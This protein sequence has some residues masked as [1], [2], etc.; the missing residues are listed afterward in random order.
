MARR[1]RHLEHHRHVALLGHA[2][3]RRGLGNAGHQA[4]KHQQPLVKHKVETH[5]ALLQQRGNLL[6]TARTTRLLVSAVGQVNGARRL[7]AAGQQHLDGLHLRKQVALV[8]PRA[9]APDEAVFDLTGK[10]RHLPVALGA[11]RHGHHVLV[12]HQHHGPGLRVG[13]LPGVEQAQVIHHLA[14]QCGMHARKARL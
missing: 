1:G 3:E 4:F 13:A 12:R 6:G 9:P 5:A 7:V 14:L 2:D 8:V 11:G 10:R